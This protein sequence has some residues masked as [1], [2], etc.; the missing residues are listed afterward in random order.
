MTP[1]L[2]RFAASAVLM[3]WGVVLVYLYLSGR[4]ASYLHPSFHIYTILS[5]G[6]LVLLSVTLL[7][8][9]PA[10]P[11]CGCEDHD[12]AAGPFSGGI[13]SLLLLTV[14]LLASTKISQSSFGATAVMNRGMVQNIAD[15]PGFSP[16]FEPGL[17]QHDG[18][19]GEGSMMDPSLY[20]KK[21]ATGQIVAE[22]VDL[23]YAATDPIMREDFENKD[24]E[25]IG[26]ILPAR[27]GNPHGDRFNLV[28]L[29]VM[30]CA[31]DARPVSINVQSRL[32]TELPEMTW[33]KVVG[34]TTFPVEDGRHN[35][36]IIADSITETDAPIESFIY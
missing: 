4:V 23:L 24:V 27:N 9:F 3:V 10:E 1:V 18:T 5:G 32:P 28:R 22:T 21:N 29:F 13:L 15:L 31:A 20:L 2:S 11:D 36:L 16:A 33:V 12:H 35:T 17:P 19:V 14:P 8:T 34:K 26:Q 7:L 6:I 30:C 25:V